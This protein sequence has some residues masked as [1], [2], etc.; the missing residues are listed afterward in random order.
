MLYMS[1]YVTRHEAAQLAGVSVRTIDNYIKRG[2]LGA[3]HREGMR[4]IWLR[5]SDLD[6]FL[7]IRPKARTRGPILSL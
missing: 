6:E 7:T 5:R 4:T 3:Y 2:R 1:E